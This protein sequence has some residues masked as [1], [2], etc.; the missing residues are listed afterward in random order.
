MD[1]MNF[2]HILNDYFLLETA[3]MQTTGSSFRDPRTRDDV[4]APRFKQLVSLAQKYS[5]PLKLEIMPAGLALHKQNSTIKKGT[6]ILWRVDLTFAKAQTTVSSHRFCD[7]WCWRWLLEQ[8]LLPGGCQA[9]LALQQVRKKGGN[10]AAS[11]PSISSSSASIS[12]TCP[13]SAS[14]TTASTAL[15]ASASSASSV[16]SDFSSTILSDSAPFVAFASSST[17][18]SSTVP[19]GVS[20]LPETSSFVIATSSSLTPSSLTSSDPVFEPPQKRQRRNNRN[21]KRNNKRNNENNN[22]NDHNNNNNGE[23]E[24]DNDIKRG[25]KREREE[26]VEVNA[27]TRHRLKAYHQAG[28][29]ALKIFMQIPF[30]PANQPAYCEIDLDSTVAGFLGGKRLVEYPQVFVALPDEVCL[31]PCL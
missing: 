1:Q 4:L 8:H 9:I 19:F 14:T 26:G 23:D 21:N 29:S 30:R 11:S 3:H 15:S 24:E 16:P 7:Q 12:S 31:Y 17:E 6:S 13:C 25:H 10:K 20:D 28:I 22:D 5:P 18:T 2:N 27:L